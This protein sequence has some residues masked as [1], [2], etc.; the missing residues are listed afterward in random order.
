MDRITELDAFVRTVDLSSQT[1]AAESMG[2]SRMAVS[3]LIQALEARLGVSLMERNTRRQMLTAAGAAYLREARAVLGQYQ[4]LVGRQKAPGRERLRIS[5]PTSFGFRCLVPLLAAFSAAHPNIEHE[6][7]LND[8][9]VNLID[10]GFDVAIRI[11]N[12]IEPH[13]NARRLARSR[14]VICGA[15]AYLSARGA[16][17]APEDLKHHACLRYAYAEHGRDWVLRDADQVVH[18]VPV[19]GPISCN[20]GDALVAAAIA[21]AGLILQPRFIVQEALTRGDLVPVLTRYSTKT[22]A[23]QAVQAATALPPSAA[24]TLTEFL[25]S[26]CRDADF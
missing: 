1:A 22:F 21:G 6:L 19:G 11:S 26:A 2:V 7:I 17:A 10:E 15:P 9:L 20:N 24:M 4:A 3:R 23:I 8:R 12:H 25:A 14:T 18:R 13:L 16:P 5:A